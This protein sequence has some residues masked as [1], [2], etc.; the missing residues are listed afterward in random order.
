MKF[1]P[2]INPIFHI[3]NGGS[4][5]K[6]EAYNLKRCGVKSGVP[7]IFLAIPSNGFHG[8][9]IEMKTESNKETD[10]QR[11]MSQ[12]LMTRGYRCVVAYNSQEA[13]DIIEDY[14][15]VEKEG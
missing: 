7:D 6:I 11:T 3:P 4:R 1:K 13:V 9:F 2:E 5:N 8:L 10:N 15:R 14:L 12:L